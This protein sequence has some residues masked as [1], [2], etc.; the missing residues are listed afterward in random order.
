MT[1]IALALYGPMTGFASLHHVQ[2]DRTEQVRRT[3]LYD[4]HS[5]L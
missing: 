1:V 5:S 4:E 2:Q 3:V